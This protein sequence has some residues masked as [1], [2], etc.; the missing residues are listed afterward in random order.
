MIK[1][2][3]WEWPGNRV[4]MFLGLHILPS[5]DLMCLQKVCTEHLTI[6]LAIMIGEQRVMYSEN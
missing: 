4:H 1:N 3:N 5:P 6:C 2:W